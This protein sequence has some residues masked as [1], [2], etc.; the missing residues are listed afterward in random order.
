MDRVADFAAV[1]LSSVPECVST[2]RTR[3]ALAAVTAVREALL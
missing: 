2:T 3:T 1:V